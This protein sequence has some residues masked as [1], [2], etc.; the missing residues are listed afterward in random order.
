MS[1]DDPHWASSLAASFLERVQLNHADEEVQLERERAEK[2]EAELARLESSRLWKAMAPLRRSDKKREVEATTSPGDLVP[3]IKLPPKTDVEQRRKGLANRLA[4]VAGQYGVEVTANDLPAALDAVKQLLDRNADDRQLAWVTYIA[5]VAK[6][7]VDIDMLRFYT[8]LQ[9]NGVQAALEQ[10]LIANTERPSVWTLRSGMRFETR[11]IID[12]TTTSRRQLHT[13]IQRVVRSV[14][15][16]WMKLGDAELTVWA[17]KGMVFRP[18]NEI[19]RTRILDFQPNIRVDG[20]KG[21]EP[22]T[23]LVP[24]NTTV[25]VPEPTMEFDRTVALT[26][27][28]NWSGSSVSTVLHDVLAVSSPEWFTDESRIKLTNYTP[29]LRTSSRVSAVSATSADNL[30]ALLPA[31]TDPVITAEGISSH[32]LPVDAVELVPEEFEATKAELGGIPGL[33]I[34]LAVSSI[35]PR[36]NHLI[37]LRAAEKLWQEGVGF[38]LLI[39]GWGAWHNDG[40]AVELE[41]LQAK[42]RPIRIIRRATELQLWTAY[43]LASFSVFISLAE[44]YGLPAA[45]SLAAGVPVV[46]SNYG[47]MAEVGEGGGTLPVDPR[48]LDAVS[49]AMRELLTNPARLDELKQQAA[50]RSK[51]TWSDYAAATWEWLV[52]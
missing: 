27:L 35:D 11:P 3:G 29:V 47:A 51:Q 36:K 22:D 48:D 10:L 5:I 2:A 23:I 45:E 31:F 52:P 1:T 19:E 50:A 42:G 15:P 43:R 17:G 12:P 25:V 49:A 41:R 18:A 4:A 38:Q 8:D 30:R 7:P 16:E 32:L 14:V 6:Y 39:I 44:G 37:L 9:V 21:K 24:W 26:A 33:P 20:D 13:G 46:L 40:F 28:A 34:V